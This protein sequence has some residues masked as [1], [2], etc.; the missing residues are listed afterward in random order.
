MIKFLALLTMSEGEVNPIIT[1]MA[2]IDKDLVI[3]E[4]VFPENLNALID[5]NCII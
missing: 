5:I 1:I 4:I 3:L 2:L